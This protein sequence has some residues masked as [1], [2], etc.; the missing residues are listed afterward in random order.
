MKQHSIAMETIKKFLTEAPVLRYYDV[1]K[2]VTV[3]CDAS[4]TGLIL[5]QD[6][7]PVCYASRALTDTETCYAQI[8]TDIFGDDNM[9]MAGLIDATSPEDFDTKLHS[10]A[11]V[12]DDCERNA[13]STSQ[14][15]F[16]RFFLVYVASEIKKKMLLPVRREAGLGDDFFSDNAS[17]IINHRFKVKVW[18][19]K[20]TT[21]PSGHKS[22]NC[23]WVEAIDVYHRML[24]ETH[25]NMHRAVIGLGP[26]HLA[27]QCKNCKVDPVV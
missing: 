3:Q 21:V 1:T 5:M 4:Q 14:P 25:R 2:P 11:S 18:E 7:Q 22:L 9:K 16:Y 10:L 19:Q 13:R 27:D 20:S 17:E 6:G 26:Y 12:W 8:E 24:A 23:T 15:E